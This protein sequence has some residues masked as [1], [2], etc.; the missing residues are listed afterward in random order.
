M[1]FVAVNNKTS[2]FYQNHRFNTHMPIRNG[3]LY[4][5]L[6]NCSFLAEKFVVIRH[7]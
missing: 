7:V 4:G 3:A 6:L 5:M 1:T 2:P